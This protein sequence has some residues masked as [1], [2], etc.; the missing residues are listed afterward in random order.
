MSCP[1]RNN[2]SNMNKL[3]ALIVM[4]LIGLGFGFLFIKY[5]LPVVT[6]PLKEVIAK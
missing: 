3:F 2:T 5:V 4:S 1:R 6:A